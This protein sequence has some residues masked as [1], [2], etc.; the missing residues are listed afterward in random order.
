M[1][2]ALLDEA[3]VQRGMCDV[4]VQYELNNTLSEIWWF[5][6]CCIIEICWLSKQLNEVTRLCFHLQQEKP[7][8][9]DPLDYEAVIS[10]LGDELK[11][12]PLKDLILFPDNDFSVSVCVCVHFIL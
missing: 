4:Y 2:P 11:D 10:E 3:S 8:L 1:F 7:K 12:D 6:P 5:V 9:I